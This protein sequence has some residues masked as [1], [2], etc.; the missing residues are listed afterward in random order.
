MLYTKPHN[1]CSVQRS[2]LVM[3]VR[4]SLLNLVGHKILQMHHII[5]KVTCGNTSKYQL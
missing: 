3:T 2:D 4:V 5:L 1:L